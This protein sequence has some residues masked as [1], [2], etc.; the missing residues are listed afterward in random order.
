MIKIVIAD[1]HQLIIDGLTAMLNSHEDLHIIGQARNG[2]ELIRSG[3]SP[4]P[5]LV[6]MDIGMPEM[7]GIEASR[8]IRESHPQIKI[9]VLTTYADHRKIREMLKTGVEGYVLKDSGSELFL[10]A[11]RAIAAGKTYYDSR[12]TEVMMESLRPK[13]AAVFA[14]TPLTDREKDVIRLIAEGKSTAEMAEALFLS[15]LT[16]ETHRKNIYTKLGMNKV[17][18]LVRYAIDEGLLD[19]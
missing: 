19:E 4:E 6:L 14:P 13:K 11:I 17:A 5:D 15:T 7:D 9:L 1:D 2:K 16:I 18:S 10:E 3:L 12:V 8:A